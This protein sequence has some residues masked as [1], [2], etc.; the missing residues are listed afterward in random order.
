MTK[1]SVI[2][3]TAREENES[4]FPQ[5]KDIAES[6]R[7]EKFCIYRPL[8]LVKEPFRSLLLKCVKKEMKSFLEPTLES[9][10]LQTFRDFEVIIVDWHADER[11]W[12][13]E[14]YS[15]K[16]TITHVRDKPCKWFEMKTPE[17][18][19]AQVQPAFPNVS[20]ARNFGA[21]IA[22]GELLMFLDDNIILEPTVIETVWKWH[23]KGYGVKLIRNRY[24]VEGDKIKLYHEFRG[25]SR[26]NV[27]WERGRCTHTYRGA[28]SHGFTV[29]LK[30]FLEV[31][32]FEEVLIAGTVGGEDID[33]ANRLHNYL[34]RGREQRM[35]LDTNA[36]IWEIGHVHIQQYRP[37]VRLNILLLDIVRDWEKDI[38]ANTRK[39]TKEELKRYKEEM[40]RRGETLHPYWDKFLVEPFNLKELRERYQRGDLEW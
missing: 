7:K 32:G 3:S 29:P 30:V 18:F 11:K 8:Y 5:W 12:V 15:D 1:V 35:V 33:L 31:N 4:F 40:I 14:K 2:I 22:K 6:I 16:L 34:E 10:L 9:L 27:L 39:P 19:E 25:D 28:W 21:M 17:G 36:T 20:G 24:D 38:L 13:S 37:C 26:Y 23:K